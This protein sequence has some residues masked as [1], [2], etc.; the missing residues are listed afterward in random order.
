MKLLIGVYYSREEP[1]CLFSKPLEARG[2]IPHNGGMKK[3]F[4]LLVLC[5]VPVLTQAAFHEA[6]AQ[7]EGWEILPHNRPFPLV[8][9]DT[10]EIRTAL[11]PNSRNELEAEV[12][13]Y[14]SFMGWKGN[15]HDE[16][17][18]THFGLEGNGYYIMR[19]QGSRFPLVSTDG[20]IGLYFE[21]AQKNAAVQ[22]RYTHISAHLSDDGIKAGRSTIQYSREFLHLRYAKMFSFFGEAFAY[23]G[24]QYLTNTDPHDIPKHGAD[25]GFYSLFTPISAHLR[26]YFG[27]DYK[28]RNTHEGSTFDLTTGLALL[29][30][31]APHG[32]PPIRFGFHYLQGHDPR[33]QFYGE[34]RK[35]F[36]GGLE[37]D[38]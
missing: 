13:S 33:G 8:V 27:A 19:H 12:G 21:A 28:I 7:Q 6:E 24:Y 26:P 23:L 16:A 30:S 32:A 37:M 10:R 9:A 18:V 25:F 38:L 5:A 35:K 29:S 15:F 36:S 1:L 2:K 3:I 34:H 17:I 22:V 11:R 20:L 14:R 4:L 31:Q